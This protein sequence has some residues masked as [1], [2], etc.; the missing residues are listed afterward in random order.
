[1]RDIVERWHRRFSGIE[2]S[3]KYL[4]YEPLEPHEKDQLSVFVDIWR[5]RLFDISW[6][7]R[8]LNETTARKANQEE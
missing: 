4:A 6:M 3:R 1:M 8:A 2:A 7:M 5:S